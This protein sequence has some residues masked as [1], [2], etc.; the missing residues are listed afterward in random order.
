M[1]N[2]PAATEAP[3]IALVPEDDIIAAMESQTRETEK[4]LRS[5][6]E[7]KA[8]FRYAPDKWTIKTLV[9]H[10]TDAER[11]FAYRLLAIARGEKQSLPGFEEND[12]AEASAADERKFSDLIDEYRA[13]RAAT[14]SLLRGLS[15]AA[16]ERTGTANDKPTTVRALAFGVLGHE[17]H[18]LKVLREKYGVR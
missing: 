10:F 13:V 2:R 15:S 18:H 9:R 8:A 12:Y 7:Q 1:S 3:Y 17:R 6:G 11:I 5:I 16:W 14:L 4:L